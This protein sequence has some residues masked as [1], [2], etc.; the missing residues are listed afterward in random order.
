MLQTLQ[1]HRD[2]LGD[3]FGPTDKVEQ[4]GS[5]HLGGMK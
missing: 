3:T 4:G 2:T 1:T 5:P